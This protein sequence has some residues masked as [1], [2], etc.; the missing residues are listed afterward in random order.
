MATDGFYRLRDGDLF[1]APDSVGAL[2]YDLHRDLR[3][4]Y[5]YPVDGWR[6]FDTEND[7]RTFYGMAKLES[8]DDPSVPVPRWV[9]FGVALGTSPEVNQ[10]VATLAQVAPVLHL[11]IGVGLGQAAKGDPKTFIGAWTQCRGAG[12]VSA[13]LLAAVVELAGGF[14]LPAD[15][16]AALAA[17]P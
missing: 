1:Y 13:D 9:E 12:L 8:A 4:T 15:F 5:E 11:M 14:S 17:M 3:H 6:W 16:V 7:A 10:F 2:D